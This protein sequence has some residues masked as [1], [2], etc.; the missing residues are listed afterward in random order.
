MKK[1]LTFILMLFTLLLAL[2]FQNTYAKGTTIDAFRYKTRN[3]IS[4]PIKIFSNTT[5]LLP[6]SDYQYIPFL[7]SAWLW[8]YP[9]M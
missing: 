9:A 5:G 7:L 6:C 1:V 3:I 8:I 4:H 2:P